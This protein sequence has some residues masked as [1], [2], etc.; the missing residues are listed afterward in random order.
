[1]IR[2]HYLDIGRI[3]DNVDV[4]KIFKVI[5]EHGGVARFVGGAV[6][7]AL[8]GEPVGNLDLSTDLS[9]DELAE[10]C[11]DAGI[12]TMPVGLKTD[13]LGVAAG[14]MLLEISSLKKQQTDARGHK[15]IEFT[16]NWAEDASRRDLTV[17]AVYADENGNV[18]DYYN[19]IEDLEKGVIRFIGDA[20]AKIREDCSRILR[21]FRF[22]SLYGK[23]PVDEKSLKACRENA[24]GLK[25][26]PA[27][28]IRDEFLKI[29]LTDNA[30]AVLELM[31][32]NGILADQLSRQPFP[33]KLR[34][35]VALER[36]YAFSPDPIRRLFVLARPD[37]T[38]AENIAL[39]L[40]L[41]KK[42]KEHLVR[43]AE[44][45]CRA[46]KL[47]RPTAQKQNIYLF[48]KDFCLDCLL[49]E[50]AAN[51]A[52]NP[53]L[54]RLIKEIRES[55]VPVFPLSGKDIIH[56]GI[57]GNAN[58]G[59]ARDRLETLW[60]DSGFNLT[61]GELL[62]TLQETKKPV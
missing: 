16:D 53:E 3:T 57:T 1:M 34:K 21:F 44:N 8:A 2:D 14:S 37:K 36:K 19:G 17:N 22:Y 54:P 27:E 15:K 47:N 26:L 35:L 51:V 9:P 10:A 23:A 29:L 45:K 48:G 56:A 25:K 60:F 13:T 30:A 62:K 42:Q 52:D 24:D 59:A 20:N 43:L 38:L 61:R 41:T 18:F 12:R 55:V 40:K 58:I 28:R 50:E 49:T 11:E 39:R 31:F 7:N 6:R 33:D 32:A 46:E 5:R 4:L